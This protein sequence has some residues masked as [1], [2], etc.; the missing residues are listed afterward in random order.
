MVSASLTII[1]TELVVVAL[2]SAYIM[3]YFKS[4]M[5]SFDVAFTVYIAW[6]LGFSGVLFLP[7][8]L[9]FALVHDVQSYRL[10][11]VWKSIYWGT[12]FLA[13]I[14]LPFQM[15][16]H[17]S[18]S[19][20][21]AG[22]ALDALKMNCLVAF[23]AI[24]AGLIF[25][26]YMMVYG[27]GTFNHVIGFM[28]AAGNTYGLLLIV[29]LMGNGLVALPRRLWQISDYGKEQIRYFLLASTVEA[30]YHEARY[31][32]EDCEAEVSRLYEAATDRR[33][34]VKCSEECF[35]YIAVIRDRAINFEFSE[36]STSL[37]HSGSDTDG[38]AIQD[39]DV[40]S[41]LTKSNLSSLH[42][43]L[44]RIQRKV[45]ATERRWKSLVQDCKNLEAL[46]QGQPLEADD[47][48]CKMGVS[49]STATSLA[50]NSC[51]R[52]FNNTC[53]SMYQFWMTKCF[54]TTC[55]V[56]SVCCSVASCIILWSEM[57]M[58]SN[59]RSP[60][61]GI[62][63]AYQ[64]K[65]DYVVVIQSI[66]F[67]ALFYMSVCTYWSLFQI[68]L[69]WQYRL[70]GPQLSSYPSL[71]FNAQYFSRLQFSLGFNFLMTLNTKSSDL[72]AF[73]GLMSNI[74]IVPLF[75]TSFT[76]YTPIIMIIIALMTLFNVY[77]RVLRIF[78][79]ESEELIGPSFPCLTNSTFTLSKE[80]ED[81]AAAGKKL[82]EAQIKRDVK[83]AQLHSRSSPNRNPIE[84]RN[85]RSDHESLMHG[86]MHSSSSS[87]S[88]HKD[89]NG[90]SSGVNRSTMMR[91]EGK[92]VYTPIVQMTRLKPR[93]VDID[94]ILDENDD[95]IEEFNFDISD[96]GDDV[97]KSDEGRSVNTTIG[98][99]GYLVNLD[100]EVR[101]E[102]PVYG[103]RY[104]NI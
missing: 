96:H 58:A 82:I 9:S 27:H 1:V 52:W 102:S 17:S 97:T 63:D 54:Q 103:G 45:K 38:G 2:L 91:I 61:G 3:H 60:L 86:S 56:L 32:L 41:L 71:V 95:G 104:S 93:E 44:S 21:F 46:M 68:N 101:S 33:A 53:A 70:A 48:W 65:G 64:G 18:G 67:L 22:K 81:L 89:T 13:W 24:G 76:V 34:V 47:V 50:E 4:P 98:E 92:P 39:R 26:I 84:G 35:G 94:A 5:V 20:N 19:F 69:G 40:S 6:V 72:T 25:L 73:S 10:S 51:L 55:R 29:L 37:K 87:V 12:F 79:F 31:D 78:G 23:L 100:D 11:V 62:M 90:G 99:G 36:R 7:Y 80:D 42:A 77:S 16:F 75:G 28:M 15:E 88:D 30:D 49:T 66:A 85:D 74:A 59:L 14:I 83:S 8:D 43:K 57:L